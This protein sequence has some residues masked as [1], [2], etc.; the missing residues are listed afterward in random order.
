METQERKAEYVRIR[1]T[2]QGVAKVVDEVK[3]NA[4]GPRVA[5][6]AGDADS[7]NEDIVRNFEERVS[8]AENQ[9]LKSGG[10]M[11]EVMA[12]I[13]QLENRDVERAGEVVSL[14]KWMVDNLNEIVAEVEKELKEIRELSVSA[15][16]VAQAAWDTADETKIKAAEG[17]EDVKGVM[18]RVHELMQVSVST[19]QVVGLSRSQ[20]GTPG[21]TNGAVRSIDNRPTSAPVVRT[22]D[23]R[24]VKRLGESLE[25]SALKRIHTTPK[26]A[27]DFLFHAHLT[28]IPA[29]PSG[30]DAVSMMHRLFDDVI[31][32]QSK[33]CWADVNN[34]RLRLSFR[35]DDLAKKFTEKWNNTNRGLYQEIIALYGIETGRASNGVGSNWILDGLRNRASSSRGF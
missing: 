6:S 26:K 32:G 31:P 9:V 20:T 3:A 16:Q 13:R 14:Q 1:A 28:P 29:M 34:G 25:S 4:A 7:G 2:I 19:P 30:E 8:S 21:S 24:G 15:Q 23:N 11:D 22:I 10:R 33:D 17:R 5:L 12:R 35:T 18:D 27:S